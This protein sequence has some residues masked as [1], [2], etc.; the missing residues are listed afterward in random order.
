MREHKHNY[1][2][3]D[4]FKLETLQPNFAELE[5]AFTYYYL[6]HLYQRKILNEEKPFE[7]FKKNWM[8]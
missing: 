1:V 3:L 5:E 8:N 4:S 7:A 6:L 2:F